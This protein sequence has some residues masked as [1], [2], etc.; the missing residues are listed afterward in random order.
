MFPGAESLIPKTDIFPFFPLN[1]FPRT[2]YSWAGQERSSDLSGSWGFWEFLRWFSGFRE[3][4]LSSYW[5][6]L[7]L[8]RH[9]TG[10]QSLLS[11]L[12]QAY[13]ELGLLMLLLTVTVITISRLTKH[14]IFHILKEKLIWK[15]FS[16][17]VFIITWQFLVKLSLKDLLRRKI[18]FFKRQNRQ[19]AA[20]RKKVL[21]FWI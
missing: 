17:Y 5:I 8:V 19:C 2:L 1:I 12:Q 15:M 3:I 16:K 10:L 7:Q 9:F 11:T 13:Q 18:V 20:L 6:Q 14:F 4:L 21:N